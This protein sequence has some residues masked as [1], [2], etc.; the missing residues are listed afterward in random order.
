M[1][2]PGRSDIVELRSLKVLAFGN[3]KFVGKLPNTNSY[4]ASQ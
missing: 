1:A 2:A 4:L 3:L